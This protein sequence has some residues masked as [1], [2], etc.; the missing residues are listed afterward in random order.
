MST[1]GIAVVV[2]FDYRPEQALRCE[3]EGD[4]GEP[5]N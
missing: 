3:V 5:R 4:L 1:T 2:Q